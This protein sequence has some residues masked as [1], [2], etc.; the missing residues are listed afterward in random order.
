MHLSLCPLSTVQ[1]IGEVPNLTRFLSTAQPAVEEM[2]Y[3]AE[4]SGLAIEEPARDREEVSRRYESSLMAFLVRKV[5][6]AAEEALAALDENTPMPEPK[7]ASDP[8]MSGLFVTMSV[9]VAVTLYC[10]SSPPQPPS[11]SAKPPPS[12]EPKNLPQPAPAP[13]NKNPSKSEPSL[14]PLSPPP[15][16]LPV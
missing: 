15:S 2:N 13:D 9:S 3:N 5:F 14:V 12:P 11:P 6:A 8:S 1:F 4:K 7:K 10:A 16:H